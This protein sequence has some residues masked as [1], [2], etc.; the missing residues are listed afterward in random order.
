MTWPPA[1]SLNTVSRRRRDWSS[2][3]RAYF[4]SNDAS[5]HD[6][7]GGEHK[8]CRGE[9]ASE[10][11]M[12][13]ISPAASMKLAAASSSRFFVWLFF[14]L[15]FLHIKTNEVKIWWNYESTPNLNWEMTSLHKKKYKNKRNNQINPSKTNKNCVKIKEKIASKLNWNTMCMGCLPSS[16][17][18][19]CPQPDSFLFTPQ[20]KPVPPNI[21][22]V[23]AHFQTVQNMASND[24]HSLYEYCPL[25][26]S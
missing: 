21:C 23:V 22:F 1:N 6:L 25:C 20:L 9:F 16:A 18:F 11:C 14:S 5:Q 17:W 24:D 19:I 10:I 4:F 8:S 26:Y 2:P 7:A 15:N 3:R 13:A 12:G